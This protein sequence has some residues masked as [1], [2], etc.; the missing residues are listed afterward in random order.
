MKSEGCH[1]P[2]H[3]E[4]TD[5]KCDPDTYYKIFKSQRLAEM[6]E[7]ESAF[8]VAIKYQQNPGDNI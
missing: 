6:N 4:K 8:Y 1:S 2:G 5:H 3:S 7:P